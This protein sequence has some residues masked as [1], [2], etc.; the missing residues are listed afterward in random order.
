MS[1]GGNDK[2]IK[3]RHLEL[4]KLSLSCLA[5]INRQNPEAAALLIQHRDTI[6]N[7]CLQKFRLS[8]NRSYQNFIDFKVYIQEDR[9]HLKEFFFSLMRCEALP[10]QQGNAVTSLLSLL[11]SCL[12]NGDN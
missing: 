12:Q 5:Y 11:L 4:L 10:D 7:L 1:D 3:H 2:V 6:V 9:V 8:F